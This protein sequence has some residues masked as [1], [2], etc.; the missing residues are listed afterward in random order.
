MKTFVRVDDDSQT[1]ADICHGLEF[2][3]VKIDDAK[4]EAASRKEAVFSTEDSRVEVMVLP[5]NEEIMIALDTVEVIGK[6]K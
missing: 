6:N 1:R 2:M 3:G 4:N 5:T